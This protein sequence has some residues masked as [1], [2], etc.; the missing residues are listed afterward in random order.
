[1]S[2][3]KV[4]KK[5]YTKIGL[6]AGLSGRSSSAKSN[7]S[8]HSAVRANLGGSV[9]GK[10][11]PKMQTKLQNSNLQKPLRN[12]DWKQD[13]KIQKPL[14]DKLFIYGINPVIN[15]INNP[16]R[17][18]HQIFISRNINQQNLQNIL[19]AV[20]P[21]IL[22][23]SNLIQRVEEEKI[24]EMIHRKS[25]YKAKSGNNSGSNV[26]HQGVLAICDYQLFSNQF[27]LLSKLHSIKLDEESLQKNPLPTLLMLD[28]ITDPQNFGAIIRS[29][30]AFGVY[31]I[32]IPEH[33]A[34][35]ETA[36]VVKASAGNI[37]FAKIYIINNFSELIKK[38]KDLGYWVVGLDGTASD[39][40][41]KISNYRPLVIVAGS[42]GSGIRQLVKKSCDLLLKIDID[43]QVESLNVGAATAIAL[44]R[45]KSCL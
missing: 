20:S 35:K 45:V 11:S 19:T 12:S 13:D 28:Q 31:N 36:S 33:N 6:S 44:H 16:S 17:N 43:P 41:E 38:L 22:V 1:M 32:I 7:S 37:E 9:S 4:K 27:D 24:L 2:A 39:G 29:A 40:I 25:F 34:V 30:V 14:D 26:V 18:I 15:A 21:R 8:R 42:E 5:S 10:S 3:K 23:N